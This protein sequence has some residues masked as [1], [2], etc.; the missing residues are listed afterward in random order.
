MTSLQNPTRFMSLLRRKWVNLLFLFISTIC[1]SI[2]VLVA[3]F[4]AIIRYSILSKI[5]LETQRDLIIILI[6]FGI[7]SLLICFAFTK[8][9]ALKIASGIFLVVAL[10]NI[11]LFLFIIKPH[12][13]SGSSMAPIILDQEY[14]LGNW[15]LY[16]FSPVKR[17]DIVIFSAPDFPDEDRISRIIG[18]PGEYISIRQGKVYINGNPLSEPY[19]TSG[20]TTGSGRFITDKDVLIPNLHYVVLGDQRQHS[21]D[22]R[23]YGFVGA[24]SIKET[25]FYIYWPLNRMRSIVSGVTS[26][27]FYSCRTLNT[28]MIVGPDGKG[29]IGCDIEVDGQ[30]DLSQS[31][32]E[33]QKTHTK[34]ALIPD[35]YERPNRYFETLTGLY[36]DE[37]VKVFVY[38]NTGFKIECLPSLNK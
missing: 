9:K 1:F 17:G 29:E 25:V 14:V 34:K 2:V 11:F 5:P 19:L 4:D 38:T 8:I 31:Y 28:K 26:L 6:F 33:G 27:P 23:F 22:S 12:R 7:L 16:N 35:S 36:L 20:T 21:F 18:L 3:F 37:E 32:C 15:A 10:I 24:G 30:I 13:I